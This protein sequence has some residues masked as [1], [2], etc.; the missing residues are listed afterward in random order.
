MI[1]FRS[2]SVVIGRCPF[3]G[4][5]FPSPSAREDKVNY[6][7]RQYQISPCMPALPGVAARIRADLESVCLCARLIVAGPQGD[8]YVVAAPGAYLVEI[9]AQTGAGIR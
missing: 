9:R 5:H 3:S 8:R 7:D 1:S 4:P 6:T 2:A